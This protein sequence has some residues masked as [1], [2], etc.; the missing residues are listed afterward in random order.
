MA[1]WNVGHALLNS[2]AVPDED[3]NWL[4]LFKLAQP[5]VLEQFSKGVIDMWGGLVPA[6]SD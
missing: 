2:C 3:Y 1:A 5:L 6:K 4:D